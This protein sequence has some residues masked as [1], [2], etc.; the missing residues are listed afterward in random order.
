MWFILKFSTLKSTA[1]TSHAPVL[2]QGYSWIITFLGLDSQVRVM[3]QESAR[4][5]AGCLLI[6]DLPDLL[7]E[8][9]YWTKPGQGPEAVPTGGTQLWPRLGEAWGQTLNDFRNTC[10]TSGN[11]DK[12][13]I[14]SLVF[15]LSL[16]PFLSKNFES[17]RH[18]ALG[19]EWQTSQTRSLITWK[20]CCSGN[21]KQM[22]K[23]KNKQISF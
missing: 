6:Q 12:T 23:H 4:A 22:S 14:V 19:I 2:K 7:V 15:F 9:K 18:Y 10:T 5:Q 21:R 16:P 11:G 20:L 17:A 1:L 13:R 3:F 8:L